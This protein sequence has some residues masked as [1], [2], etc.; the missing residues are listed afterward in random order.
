[1]KLT[2]LS[3][4]EPRSLSP[5]LCGHRRYEVSEGRRILT[6]CLCWAVVWTVALAVYAEPPDFVTQLNQAHEAMH[7]EPAKSYY[8]GPFN[9]AFYGRFSGWLNQCTQQTG[10]ALRDLDMLITLD[11]QGT[12]TEL[13]FRP[14]S[15]LT[16]CFAGQVRKE[17]FP[18]PPVGW[19]RSASQR[20]HHQAVE[21]HVCRCRPTRA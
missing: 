21:T 11:R 15:E 7:S 1:M 16:E 12:V 4:L 8:D 20:P 9:K 10:Q 14:E 19:S 13:R 17:Q 2:D 3:V 18:A 6:R 5:V